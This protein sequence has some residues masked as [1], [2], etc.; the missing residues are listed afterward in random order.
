M[1][2]FQFIDKTF[3]LTNKPTDYKSVLLLSILPSNANKHSV[4]QVGF[5]AAK[6]DLTKDIKDILMIKKTS[7]VNPDITAERVL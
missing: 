4:F 6:L 3:S 1:S 5:G 7:G 2:S